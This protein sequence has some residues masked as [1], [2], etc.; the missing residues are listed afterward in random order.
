MGARFAS[1]RSSSSFKSA[2][3][4]SMT[5][6]R[7]GLTGPKRLPRFNM[8]FEL[9]LFLGAKAYGRGQN[10]SKASLILDREPHRYQNFLS[11]IA[12]QDIE[13]HGE[14][15]LQAIAKVRNWLQSATQSIPWAVPGGKVIGERY[16]RFRLDKPQLCREAGLSIRDLTFLDSRWLIKGW[17]AATAPGVAAEKGR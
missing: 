4:A 3:S 17:L 6:S 11:D 5:S 15:P 16:E 10:A 14:R 12:G 7:T 2:G 8:P 13:A 1:T 9:G